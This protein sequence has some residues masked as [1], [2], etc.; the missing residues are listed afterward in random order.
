M[1]RD[2]DLHEKENFEFYQDNKEKQEEI[3]EFRQKLLV[4]HDTVSNIAIIQVEIER[5][6]KQRDKLNQRLAY[7]RRELNAYRSTGG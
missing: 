1:Q 4:S 5:T 6:E 3:T 7:L 2:I